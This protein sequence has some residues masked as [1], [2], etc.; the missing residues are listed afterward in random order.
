[1]TDNI[2]NTIDKIFLGFWRLYV[3]NSA[4]QGYY[5]ADLL[6]KNTRQIKTTII[7]YIFQKSGFL[8]WL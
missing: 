7:R 4:V 1:M 5:D 8:A 2:L 6:G 3:D